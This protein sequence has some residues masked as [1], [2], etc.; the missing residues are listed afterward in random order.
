MCKQDDRR[1]LLKRF[2]RLPWSTVGKTVGLWNEAMMHDHQ[3]RPWM[4]K[5]LLL[6]SLLA[7]CLWCSLSHDSVAI[8]SSM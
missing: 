1:A 8:S 7:A 5:L 3:V 2:A 4:T 6:S